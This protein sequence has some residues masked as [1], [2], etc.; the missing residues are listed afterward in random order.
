MVLNIHGE[1]PSNPDSVKY[2]FHI[3]YTNYLYLYNYY[4][5]QL[6]DFIIFIYY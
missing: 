5:I 1:V 3:S 6:T 4:M 2:Y